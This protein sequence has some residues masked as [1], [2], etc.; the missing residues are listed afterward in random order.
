MTLS[1]PPG[2][3][4]N[5]ASPLDSTTRGFYKPSRSTPSL[6]EPA[7]GPIVQRRSWPGMATSPGTR[8]QN[9]SMAWSSSTPPETT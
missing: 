7:S 1:N 2:R 3:S 9:V 6:C 4:R 5:R 8:S